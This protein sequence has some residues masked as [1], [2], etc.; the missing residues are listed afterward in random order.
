VW[1][2]QRP[3]QTVRGPLGWPGRTSR[4]W[5]HCSPPRGTD[6]NIVDILKST[7]RKPG[8]DLHGVY[9][10]AYGYGIVDAQARRHSSATL[11]SA[12]CGAARRRPAPGGHPTRD[13][14]PPTLRRFAVADRILTIDGLG[15][16][17]PYE[18]RSEREY[19]GWTSMLLSASTMLL[20]A[21]LGGAVAVDVTALVVVAAVALA[22]LALINGLRM[23]GVV[24]RFLLS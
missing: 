9:D 19:R 11:S 10:P 21:A 18:A 1:E 2:Q 3:G 8:T 13:G 7:T 4:A 23:L 24:T 20:I 6:E 12:R 5:R 16:R 17:R 15:G 22:V 14:A